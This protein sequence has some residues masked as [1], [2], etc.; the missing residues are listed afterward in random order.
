M[1]YF[2][3]SIIVIVSA[4]VILFTRYEAD[5]S[6]IAAELDSMKSMFSTVDRF[7]NTYI[8]SGGSLVNINFEEL[9]T[10]GILLGS[11][12]KSSPAA[13]TDHVK[14]SAKASTL[15]FPGSTVV[16]QIIPNVIDTSSYELL[17]DMTKNST[18]LSKGTFA[19]SFVGR[20]YCE[21]ALFGTFLT[22]GKTYDSTVGAETF[23]DDGTNKD[24]LLVC[25][26]Y[27]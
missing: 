13:T 11:I 4:M 12:E 6:A 25:I 2:V 18:L 23:K 21:K 24:G 16:W 22:K 15:T 20:E 26:V 8:E 10:N 5:D 1:Q 9:Y 19:E 27:K 3:S 14:G 7:V 17:V